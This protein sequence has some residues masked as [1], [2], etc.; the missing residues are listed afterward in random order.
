MTPVSI[1]SGV[2]EQDG[3]GGHLSCFEETLRAVSRKVT[4]REFCRNT[5]AQCHIPKRTMQYSLQNIAL[6]ELVEITFDLMMGTKK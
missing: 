1:R 3:G 4:D 5:L 2:T 6:K